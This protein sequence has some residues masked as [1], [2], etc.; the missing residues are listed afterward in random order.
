MDSVCR[1]SDRHSTYGSLVLLCAPL[2]RS[3]AERE[4]KTLSDRIYSGL[5]HHLASPHVLLSSVCIP[6]LTQKMTVTHRSYR[7]TYDPAI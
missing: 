1:M 3:T 2:P 6:K 7:R 5:Q 4:H